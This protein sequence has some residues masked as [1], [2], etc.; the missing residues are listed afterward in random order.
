MNE[1]AQIS[2]RPHFQKSEI[3]LRIQ[4]GQEMR[5]NGSRLGEDG[6]EIRT[7]PLAATLGV[8]QGK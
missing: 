2:F 4:D 7:E 8:G 3:T 1:E 5:K 6:G